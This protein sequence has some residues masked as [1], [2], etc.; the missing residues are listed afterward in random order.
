MLV[1]CV[2]VGPEVQEALQAGQ[3]LWLLTGQVQGAALVDLSQESKAR[4]VW[5][6]G[7]LLRAPDC[8]PPSER[9]GRGSYPVPPVNVGP[10]AHQQLHHV[11]LVSQDGD[12]Q[13]RVVGDGVWGHRQLVSVPPTGTFLQDPRTWPGSPAQHS[14]LRRPELSP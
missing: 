13:G 4:S 1:G 5:G 14:H 9:A 7:R 2:D 8:I 12:V 11:G 6:P 10:V 3:A